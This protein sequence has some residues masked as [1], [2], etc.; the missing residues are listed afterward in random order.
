MVDGL[1]H[2]MHVRTMQWLTEANKATRFEYLAR[3]F[4]REEIRGQGRIDYL[5]GSARSN[6]Q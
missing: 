1:R 3:R 4:G 5:S 6:L 2:K